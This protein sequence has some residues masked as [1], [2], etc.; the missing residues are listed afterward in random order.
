MSLCLSIDCASAV[1]F[2]LLLRVHVLSSLLSLCIGKSFFPLPVSSL[3]LSRFFHVLC[4]LLLL[5]LLLPCFLLSRLSFF[6]QDLAPIST[7]RVFFCTTTSS[8]SSPASSCFSSCLF[9]I[10]FFT[11]LM[12]LSSSWYSSC[13]H[14]RGL[15]LVF[16]HILLSPF[17]FIRFFLCILHFLSSRS[18]YV[19]LLSIFLC[20]A[21]GPTFLLNLWCL[22]PPP[23]PIRLVLPFSLSSSLPSLSLLLIVLSSSNPL[24]PNSLHLPFLP[25]L[26]FSSVVVLAIISSSFHFF[27]SSHHRRRP[28]PPLCLEF[29]D[30]SWQWTVRSGLFSFA[31][32]ADDRA[33]PNIDV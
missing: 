21:S 32:S 11:L 12:T 31:A 7:F 22:F 19:G 20:P 28:L 25:H 8:L 24:V 9:E 13:S 29:I 6:F 10:P 16:L 1:L 33:K 23:H 26:L 18:F 4:S 5:R 3:L 30:I 17:P 2:L 15:R 27:P 14:Y